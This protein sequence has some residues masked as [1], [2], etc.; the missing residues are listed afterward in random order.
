MLRLVRVYLPGILM[1]AGIAVIVIGT[2]SEHALETSLCDTLRAAEE[3]E[4]PIGPPQRQLP[5]GLFEGAVRRGNEWTPGG[6][7]QVDLWAMSRDLKTL[8]LFELKR[9]GNTPLGALPEA[10]YYARLLHF[11]RRGTPDG[12][13]IAGT[14]TALD[15]VRCAERIQMWL[16]VPHIHPLLLHEGRSPLSWLNG[17]MRE[18]DVALG[19]VQLET[20]A[21][22][23]WKAWDWERSW[24]GSQTPKRPPDY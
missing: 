21:D 9:S 22:G 10:L 8:H 24:H 6:R 11:F 19:I 14:S 13:V 3:F 1:I 4:P 5:I 12:R 23:R 18:E 7:S 2:A 16:A 15:L 17:G 20:D